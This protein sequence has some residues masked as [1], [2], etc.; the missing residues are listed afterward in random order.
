MYRLVSLIAIALSVCA[1]NRAPARST[2][3]C[4]IDALRPAVGSAYE[5]AELAQDV[6]HKRASLSDALVAANVAY[7]DAAKIVAAF[8]ACEPSAPDAGTEAP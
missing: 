4:Q 1:C 3:E 7:G 5:A 8:H 2:L 6:A